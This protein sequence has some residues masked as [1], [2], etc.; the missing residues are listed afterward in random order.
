MSFRLQFEKEVDID[1][2]SSLLISIGALAVRTAPQSISSHFRDLI[3]NKHFIQ[4]RSLKKIFFSDS[5]I[6]NVTMNKTDKAL[7]FYYRKSSSGRSRVQSEF[8]VSEALIYLNGFLDAMSMTLVREGVS[9]D[10]E[11]ALFSSDLDSGVYKNFI[12]NEFS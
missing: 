4:S 12:C 5:P 11:L 8:S 3:A 10:A 2:D 9:I 7:A 6:L 1:G